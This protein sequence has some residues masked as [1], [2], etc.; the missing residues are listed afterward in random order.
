LEEG[1]PA[2]G[3]DLALSFQDNG[4]CLDIWRQITQVQSKAADLFRRNG[5]D[6]AGANNLNNNP[7]FS[8]NS[9][10]DT[11]EPGDN[12][13][14]SASKSGSSVAD[15]AHAVAAAHHADLQRQEQQEMWVNVASEATQHHLEHQNSL[16]ER[17]HDHHFEDAVGGMV[18]AYHESASAAQAPQNNPQSPQLPNPPTLGNLEEIA[19]T[20]AA[21]QVCYQWKCTSL[22]ALRLFLNILMHWISWYL[23]SLFSTSNNENHWLCIYHRMNVPI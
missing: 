18:A 17:N 11:N 20:I 1:N 4:G 9:S 5:G 6:R 21:V 3:V 12:S 19:D 15:V 10:D 2:Q 13:A 16:V 22:I 23:F 8:N 7:Q 14:S